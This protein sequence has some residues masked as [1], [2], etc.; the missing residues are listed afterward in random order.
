[1]SDSLQPLESQHT[2]PPCPSPT[3]GVYSNSC[4]SSRW[5]HPGISSSVIPF[6]SCPQ[7]LPA[8]IVSIKNNGTKISGEAVE[9]PN[10][11]HIAG[12]SIKWHSHSGINLAVC[13]KTKYTAALQCS[14]CTVAIHPR[15]VKIFLHTKICT[16]KFTVALFIIVKIANNSDVLQQENGNTNYGTP[17][18][19]TTTHQ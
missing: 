17:L 12:E 8:L 1:M 11:T 9:K 6:S 7:S 5:C 16:W 2:R 4:P 3:P 19:W 14:I 13:Y 18:P 10:H 15:E